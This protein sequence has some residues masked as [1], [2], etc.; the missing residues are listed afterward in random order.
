MDANKF[1]QSITA[2]GEQYGKT[3]TPLMLKM[4]WEALKGFSNQEL[5]NAVV[6]YISDPDVCQFWPQ[7]GALISKI[8]GTSKQ[9]E[10]SIDAQAIEAWNEAYNSMIRKGQYE[11]VTL[12]DPLGMK[13]IEHLGGWYSFCMMKQSDEQWRRK[14]FI[15]AYKT[16]KGSQDLPKRLTGLGDKSH[17]KLE[18]SEQLGKL[19][20]RYD[21]ERN[22][23]D[24]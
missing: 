10:V 20:S 9:L 8:T 4:Y 2:L 5:D 7:P 13:V 23:N 24:E 18:A 22:G 6:G 15:S 11:S 21:G 16:L 17:A 12:K 14:E 1:K 19:N 3:I